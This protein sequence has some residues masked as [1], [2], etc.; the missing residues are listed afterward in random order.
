MSDTE[1]YYAEVIVDNNEL[2][3]AIKNILK[4]A[5]PYTGS[6][7]FTVTKDKLIIESRAEL[8]I[9]FIKIDV[10]S[11]KI[12]YPKI[13]F[14]LSLEQLRVATASRKGKIKLIYDNSKFI[15]AASKYRSELMT[16]DYI[17][18]PPP[19]AM[20]DAKV[21]KVTEQQSKWL[22]NSISSV[23][24]KPTAIS[25]IMP[26]NVH[27]D[28]KGIVVA[29]YARDHIVFIKDDELKGNLDFAIPIEAFAA[30]FS[31]FKDSEFTL[32]STESFLKAS[33]ESV[34]AYTSL[35]ATD[36][37]MTNDVLLPRI[38]AFLSCNSTEIEIPYKDLSAFFS[39]S[40]AVATAERAEIIFKANASKT[41]LECTS[42]N[43]SIKASFD[44]CKGEACS[45]KLDAEYL[46]EAISKTDKAKGVVIKCSQEQGFVLIPL[47][48]N[49][50]SVIA[51]NS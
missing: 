12:S 35:P 23:A 51:L 6:A 31:V 7:N 11:A 28:D 4:V 8:S 48:S 5:A 25:P 9:A 33:S 41:L 13:T 14:S 15:I 30:I 26:V 2:S 1:N 49:A 40:R 36:S 46:Q 29:C 47:K 44:G 42:V 50:Y 19:N 10:E 27:I 17:E 21:I 34:V 39:N 38:D 24:L 22:Y 18:Y 43:G 20:K 45:I 32:T 3:T 16:T 37:Y